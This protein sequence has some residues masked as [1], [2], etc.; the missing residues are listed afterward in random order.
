MPTPVIV[1]I[2]A[3]VF[4]ILTALLSA[5]NH[6]TSLKILLEIAQIRLDAAGWRVDDRH[7]MRNE[8]HIAV[9]EMR[10]AIDEEIKKFRA[11]VDRRFADSK[12]EFDRMVDR[13][14]RQFDEQ[15]Q[16]TGPRRTEGQ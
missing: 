8:V 16:A 7:N 15:R 5:W 13:I 6:F 1:A 10:D 4:S 11:E 9:S 14:H 12:G 3:L 2:C